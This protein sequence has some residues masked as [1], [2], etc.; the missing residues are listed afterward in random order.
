MFSPLSLFLVLVFGKTPLPGEEIS[1]EK[2]SVK[3]APL[4]TVIDHFASVQSV[5][6]TVIHHCAA[7]KCRCEKGNTEMKLQIAT[8]LPPFW[9]INHRN[10]INIQSLDCSSYPLSKG[11][12]GHRHPAFTTAV[13]LIWS[14]GLLAPGKP[15]WKLQM[16][17]EGCLDYSV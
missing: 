2:S 9:R 16:K 1:H 4:V 8:I 6:V 11:I 17:Q 15:S 14:M 7:Y 10:Y 12:Q 5:G 13:G 3:E